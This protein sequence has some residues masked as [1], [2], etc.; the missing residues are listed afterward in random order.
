MHRIGL[1]RPGAG[2]A[3][4]TALRTSTKMRRDYSRLSEQYRVL[5]EAAVLATPHLNH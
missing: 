4:S 1:P 2:I 3:G 5:A